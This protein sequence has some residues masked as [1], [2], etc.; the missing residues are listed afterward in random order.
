MR[1]LPRPSVRFR[2]KKTAI[3][4][5]PVAPGAIPRRNRRMQHLAHP[6]RIVD[7]AALDAVLDASLEQRGVQNA[8]PALVEQLKPILQRGRTEVETR[9]LASQD[10]A[11]AMAGNSWLIDTIIRALHRITL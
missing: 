4:D 11:A 9:F 3:A 1:S 7:P 2:R 8:Q 10:G 6:E 5:A